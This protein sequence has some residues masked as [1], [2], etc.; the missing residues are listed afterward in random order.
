MKDDVVIVTAQRELIKKK[1]T[2]TRHITTS[3]DIK[4]MSVN[5]CAGYCKSRFWFSE[6]G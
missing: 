4:N 6:G 2:N 3:D 1:E 5:I